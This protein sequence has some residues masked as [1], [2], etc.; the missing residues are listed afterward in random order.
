MTVKLEEL[1]DIVLRNADVV[2]DILK[3]LENIRA[4]EHRV[5]QALRNLC[6]R[7]EG[8]LQAFDRDKYKATDQRL[9]ISALATE[10][11][12]FDRLG[13]DLRSS[14]SEFLLG[15]SALLEGRNLPALEYLEQFLQT[16]DPTDNNYRNAN[17]L[18]GMI[19]YNRREFQRSKDFFTHAF[20][21]SPQHNRDWQ[22]KIYTAELA[23]F[24]RR[25][26]QEIEAIFQSAEEGL[27]TTE[28]NS[29][30]RFLRSTLYLKWG[31]CYVGTFLLPK[32][33]NP[34]VNNL[35]ALRYYKQAK[36]S[37]PPN[38]PADSLLP[39]VIDYSLAKALI[40]AKSV[41]IDLKQT[42]SDLLVDVFD[43]LRRIVLTK[44]EEIILAQ[45]YLM[46]ATSAYYSSRLSKDIG[47]I[48]LEYA[49]HQ[50]LVVPSD[51]CFYSCITKELLSREEFV[52]QVDFYAK[53]IER[54]IN[55]R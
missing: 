10:I 22:S 13:Y 19:T 14:S 41:D 23:Y 38:P 26:A 11:L 34:M 40:L 25:P 16:A 43:H 35:I 7:L 8:C 46:L 54:Q 24:M 20:E 55:R 51:V 47:E 5:E 33:T 28:E 2:T 15:V 37:L 31:N 42:P 27:R 53:E 21:R 6:Q 12:I 3:Q 18:A 32:T 29:Q 17:Y 9:L 52:G 4:K 50:T 45:S 44:R 1:Q 30:Q 48:Y 49:R 36:N 39:A